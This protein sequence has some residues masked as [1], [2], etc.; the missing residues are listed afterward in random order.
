EAT[1]VRARVWERIR[2]EEKL[3]PPLLEPETA[4]SFMS[5]AQKLTVAGFALLLGFGL[6]RGIKATPEATTA[7][8]IGKPAVAVR[9]EEK[10]Q[11]DFIDPAMIELASQEGF[12]MEIFPETN[13][14][15]PL[16]QEMRTALASSDEER[17]WVQQDRGMVVPVQYISQGSAPR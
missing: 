16:D 4:A 17:V 14:F 8:E 13:S 1:P 12:S 2:E 15:T 9:T 3:P 11:E 6:G 10:S 7:A 5:V